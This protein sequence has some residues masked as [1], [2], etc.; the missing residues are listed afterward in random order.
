MKNN[1][2]IFFICAMLL[3]PASLVSQA[4]RSHYSAVFERD[5][6]YRIFLP[7]DYPNSGIS[8]PVIYYFHGNTGTHVPQL[9]DEMREFVNGN[10]VIIVSWN[11]RSVDSDMRPYN[12]GF[13]SNINY[14][15][16]FKD[17]FPELVSHIDSTY[18]TLTD[19]SNRALIGHSMGG[20][21]SFFIAGK[22]PDMVGAAV[23]SK[24][25]PEFFIGYPDNHTLY[26]VR[27]MF[28]NLHGIHLRFHNSTSGELVHLNDEVH[29]GALQEGNLSYEYK[30]YEGGHSLT[31]G[32][33]TDA[34]NFILASF[35][36]PLPAPQRWH[37]ADLYPD[38]NIWGYHIDSNLDEPGFIE[39]K[40]VTRGGMGITTRNWQPDGPPVPGVT[41]HVQT[42]PLYRPDSEYTLLDYNQTRDLVKKTQLKSDAEGRI[43]FE[44][45]HESHQ[46]GISTKNDPAEIVYVG[47][48]VNEE[49][50]FLDHHQE[51]LMKLRLLNRGGK[52]GKNLKV[53]LTCSS[54]DVT[55]ANPVLVIDE[56]QP[57]SPQ[58]TTAGFKVTAHNLPPEN[59]A[60]F[61]L[62]FMLSI[63]DREQTWNDE[64]EVPVMY[65]VP[66]FTNLGI[67]DGD[68]EIFG[69]GNGNNIAEPGESIL[70][71]EVTNVPQRTRL[72]YDDPYI[73]GERLYVDLQPDK[74]G[75]GY[76]LSSVIHI[77][78][79]CP[80]GH[81]IKFLASYE[82]KDWKTIKRKVT[83]GR[84]TITVGGEK[85]TA[86]VSIEAGD[87]PN[88]TD[89]PS[90]FK[91][92]LEDLETELKS[93]RKGTAEVIATSP[94]GNPVYAVYY[95][96]R[97]DFRSQANYNS[98]VAA[99]NPAF[100]AR[101]DSATRPVVFFLGPVHGQEA[102]GMVG[103]VN[104]IHIAET[105]KDYRGKEW[106]SLKS[107]LEQCRV[108]IVP[109]GNPDGRKR[110]PYDSFLGLPTDIMTKYGQGTRTDGTS[111]GWP[112]AKSLHPME[113]NVG[114]L[115]G[116]FN[117][118][119]I[120]IMHDDFFSPMAME[121]KA[122]LDVART[123]SP[124][125]TV[126]LH[127]HENRPMILHSSY[128]PWF[129]K[130]RIDHLI[131]QLND[132]YKAEGL[133]HVPSD[134][135]G[136][137]SVEDEEFPP[138]SSFNLISAL[139]HI[140]GT[141]AFTFECSHGT[142][143]EELPEPIVTFSDILDI[144]LILYEEMLD[145]LLNNRLYWKL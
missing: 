121:T 62:K 96:E 102:E 32:E 6:P 79:D 103:L 114:I 97:E 29:A 53:E 52:P 65:D 58:W 12:I 113:G 57:G 109:C 55:I 119:G 18:R 139:H 122:I 108:I 23:N 131:R 99:Q 117:D 8:Y 107:K 67:D 14:E 9:S 17:Y 21:M 24:G 124:D 112:Q 25:S 101:K 73:D 143:S 80:I 76:A 105:G 120:N 59:G 70:V 69:S 126:S 144:Q 98:A 35:R 48:R 16:Q 90:F 38:F 111:W 47:H 129:M 42:P 13:H 43:G 49:G 115:G 68:S 91:S 22:Y 45:N 128:E 46:V 61:R 130:Q 104:L 60:P 145:Y 1:Q 3:L 87:P 95:G 26:H 2:S 37:H 86:Q 125:M 92:G 36:D 28:K 85:A 64:F 74:W 81:Q 50:I 71:Y 33:L 106:G 77:S 94:G 135:L 132:R 41:V 7:D 66:A 82:V 141:M 89:L 100:Y 116:Y 15:T 140:S 10:K 75:D 93:I 136:E 83:W 133:P 39:L 31:S 110:C 11:G 127:S 78:G 40:G 72:Y 137:P 138:Q 20:I 56:L 5:K 4:D 44:V 123:E 30:V 51:S 27:H 118:D 134:W 34:L 63:S 84:F 54:R 142:V 19:R 88:R